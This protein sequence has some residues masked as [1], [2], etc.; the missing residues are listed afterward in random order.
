[1]P[2]ACTV[3]SRQDAATVNSRLLAGNAISKVSR[4]FG[5]HES[6]LSRHV[7]SHMAGSI[8]REAR[9]N[10]EV[11]T[12]DLLAHLVDALNDVVAARSAA[13]GTGNISMLIRAAT[14]TQGLVGAL[15]DRLGDTGDTEA[16]RLMRDGERLAR[17]VGSVTRQH[18]ETGRAIARHLR[19]VG[20]TETAVA[21]ETLANASTDIRET[22]IS[23]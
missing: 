17:A 22:G 15:L 4:E 12:T 23:S 9:A 13:L 7:R 16:V 11:G 10:S 2:R 14:A 18:P 21:L 3:C 19:A 6:S 5:I 1:M 8:L 20:D